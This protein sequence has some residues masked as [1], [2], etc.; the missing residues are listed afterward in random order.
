MGGRVTVRA[1]TIGLVER[2]V[3]EGAYR[4]ALLNHAAGLSDD[5]YERAGADPFT[6]LVADYAQTRI[7]TPPSEQG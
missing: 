6:A 1:R 3:A 2:N 5:W 4:D 7:E